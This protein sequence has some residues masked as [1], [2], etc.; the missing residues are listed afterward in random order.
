MKIAKEKWLARLKP[1]HKHFSNKVYSKIGT[2]V[3]NLLQ[4]LRKRSSECKDSTFSVTRDELELKLY[5]AYGRPCPYCGKQLK[6]NKSNG[7]VCDHIV[8]LV[9]GGDSS[10]ENLQFIC[11]TCNTRKDVLSHDDF[12]ALLDWLNTQSKNLRL[13]VLGKLSKQRF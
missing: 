13:H 4:S 9:A 8:P 2:K 1:I 12:Q 3:S 7:M 5:N 10:N 6:V 11:R